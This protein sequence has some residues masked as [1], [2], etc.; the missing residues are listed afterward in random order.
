[1]ISLSF[2]ANKLFAS[3]AY[4]HEGSLYKVS[5]LGDE[6]IDIEKIDEGQLVYKANVYEG[7]SPIINLCTK[8][9][10]PSLVI[11]YMKTAKNFTPLLKRSS[12]KIE[13]INH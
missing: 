5:Y 12:N 1:V 9:K 11:G 13:K 8:E 6:N 10:F 7:V 3:G 2:S 4:C